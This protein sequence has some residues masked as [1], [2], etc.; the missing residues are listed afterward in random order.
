MRAR[1]FIPEQRIYYTPDSATYRGDK[2]PSVD[3]D[4]IMIRRKYA[5]EP[6]HDSVSRMRDPTTDIEKIERKIDLKNLQTVI[7][8][9]LSELKPYEREA[10]VNMFWNGMNYRQVGEVMGK[11]QQWAISTI[12]K[13]LRRLRIPQRSQ[14]TKDFYSDL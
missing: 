6:S 5:G 9:Q 2:M 1:D 12:T 14:H 13:A 3:P 10:L 11:S 7:K 8:K 4:D